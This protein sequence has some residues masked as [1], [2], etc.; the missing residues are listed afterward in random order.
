MT[1]RYEPRMIAVDHSATLRAEGYR[2]DAKPVPTPR[3]P[4]PPA[5]WEAKPE[6]PPAATPKPGRGRSIRV[7]LPQPDGAVV[8]QPEEAATVKRMFAAA[9]NGATDAATRDRLRKIEAE[10]NKNTRGAL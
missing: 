1:R 10:M 5:A 2:E 9:R 4:E 6:Q 3:E 7:V 8:M